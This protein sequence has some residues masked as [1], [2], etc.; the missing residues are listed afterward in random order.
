M[1][2]VLIRIAAI[3]PHSRI[4]HRLGGFDTMSFLLPVSNVARE[5]AR[6]HRIGFTI[7]ELLVVLAIVAILFILL[8][9][10]I[11]AARESAR[12][13][14]CLNQ[15]RQIGLALQEYE[16]SQGVFPPGYSQS[17][18][19]PEPPPALKVPLAAS[20]AWT[21][22]LLVSARSNLDVPEDVG[23]ADDHHPLRP[24]DDLLAIW[25]APWPIPVIK[26]VESRAPG[27]GWAAYLLPF[28]EEVGLAESIDWKVAVEDGKHETA[29]A[30]IIATYVCPSDLATGRFTVLD[31]DG[32]EIAAAATNSYCA[33]FGSYGLINV[34]P[35]EGN[36]LFQCNSRYSLK[37]VKDG[38][39]KTIAIGER[40]SVMTQTPWA[41]VMTGGTCRTRV[42]APVY[43]STAQASPAMVLARI[44][45]RT[46]NSAFSEPYD[47]FSPHRDVVNFVFAD[48][49]AR[50][51]TSDLDLEI[52]HALATRNGQEPSH[53]D[54]R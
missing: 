18:P 11:Q 19:S 39:G 47:F 53:A 42:G 24:A 22:T 5:R 44:G 8:I 45:K 26:V 16:S 50:G 7:T 27:W 14:S 40:G 37:S 46:L 17:A 48:A 31:E 23:R 20:P 4:N 3:S 29:R 10:A 43:T 36:G 13:A 21:A 52:L 51:F 30:Q 2:A 6:A 9:P 54:N 38:L 1:L 35:S 41:G 34:A 32:K 25:D 28:L 12:N 49:S 15:L 33:S